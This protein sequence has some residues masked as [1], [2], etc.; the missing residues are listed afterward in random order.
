MLSRL[1]ESLLQ[2]NKDRFVDKA[3]AAAYGDDSSN[4]DEEYVDA[5]K[6][7]AN[8][9]AV[10]KYKIDWQQPPKTLFTAI[11]S[12]YNDYTRN[13][14]S[15]S[16]RAKASREDPKTLFERA[17]LEV[18]HAGE[19]TSGKDLVILDSLE[20]SEFVFVCPLTWRACIWLDSFECGGQGAKWCLGWKGNDM[21]WKNYTSQGDL[22]V[23]ALSKTELA[24]PSGEADKLKFMVE[25]APSNKADST[26]VWLQSDSKDS[27]VRGSAA[28]KLLGH[29][30]NDLAAAAVSAVGSDDNAYT[31]STE[32]DSIWGEKYEDAL[33]SG[34]GLEYYDSSMND[35]TVIRMSQIFGESIDKLT[36]AASG[37]ETVVLDFAGDTGYVCSS[38]GKIDIM[39]SRREYDGL[40]ALLRAS[41]CKKVVV[42]ELDN[43]EVIL[44]GDIGEMSELCF[45]D[46]SIDSLTL[47]KSF[48]D[49]YKDSLE[50]KC[51]DY[52]SVS[53]IF[54][55]DCT[56]DDAA[57]YIKSK[58]I[59]QVRSNV[60]VHIWDSK[61]SK[62]VELDPWAM[63]S[64]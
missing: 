18:V 23:M 45:K 60:D 5:L 13:G 24:R 62:V 10:S 6:K 41:D 43:A 48:L 35:G 25:L 64:S 56:M 9:S 30:F 8:S 34:D 39:S 46:C 42:K 50:L 49:K 54:F 37:N 22:F 1:F 47:S 14:G 32:W 53:D 2:E 28:K 21:Y 19:D 59:K 61:K 57:R 31:E 33:E 20:N 4:V 51:L 16:Q 12:A 15:R 3:F 58:L 7:F 63:F 52:M 17:P 44:D 26:Q 29:S 36:A 38:S 27:T 55:A 40:A 11:C